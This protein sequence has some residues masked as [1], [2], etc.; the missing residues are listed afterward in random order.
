M[1]LMSN[2]TETAQSRMAKIESLR[3]SLGKLSK[4]N[5]T[6]VYALLGRKYLPLNLLR[7]K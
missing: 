2:E 4:S 3:L 6:T 5:L 7:E 1:I